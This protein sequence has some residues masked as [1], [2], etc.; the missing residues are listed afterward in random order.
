MSSA[1]SLMPPLFS[2]MVSQST[3]R[4]SYQLPS[5]EISFTVL[6]DDILI[7]VCSYF[8]RSDISSFA[9][10][11]KHCSSV[12]LPI[13]YRTISTN[14]FNTVALDRPLFCILTSAHPA[15]YVCEVLLR[16]DFPPIKPDVL[17]AG[18]RSLDYPA[19]QPVLRSLSI[20]ST[21]VVLSDVFPHS[22]RRLTPSI[23]RLEC[24]LLGT[25]PRNCISIMQSIVSTY[26]VSLSLEFTAAASQPDENHL[27]N[28]LQCI[29]RKLVNMSSFTLA[30][31]TPPNSVNSLLRDG[32]PAPQTLAFAFKSSWMVMPALCMFL[33]T[34]TYDYDT[35]Y[36]S[37][38][39]WDQDHR[40]A[41]LPS[42]VT[43]LPAPI[44]TDNV[45][46]AGPIDTT[47]SPVP[48]DSETPAASI[49]C[50]ALPHALDPR[51]QAHAHNNDDT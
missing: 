19:S 14:A 49:D 17:K 22:P 51:D 46:L 33:L 30:L 28:M 39:I 31:N 41:S 34:A 44:P 9:A 48:P 35:Q 32:T 24:P 29:V 26:L 40:S 43:P 45:V 6:P 13:V 15:S 16:S 47:S 10:V 25:R 50:S 2:G 8:T 23:L 37:V 21:T 11:S 38:I 5:L 18:I 4:S 1:H 12:L 36:I 3:I 27:F 42:L 20:C 7:E